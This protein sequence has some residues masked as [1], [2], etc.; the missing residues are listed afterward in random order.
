[1]TWFQAAAG[2]IVSALLTMTTVTLLA[3]QPMRA[4]IG[5]CFT[6]IAPAGQISKAA[7]VAA[8]AGGCVSAA[9][10]DPLMAMTIAALTAAAVGGEFSTIDQCHNMID[11]SV[12][13][14]IAE[15]LLKLPW[16]SDIKGLLQ[17]F[18][19]GKLPVKFSEL[20]FSIPALQTLPVYIE[21]GCS[22]AGA[23]GEYEKLAKEYAEA[24]K[25]CANFASDAAKAALDTVG[26][27]GESI[28][29]ALHGPS[30]HPGTQEE[31]T[32]Y[33]PTTLPDGIWTEKP[34]LGAPIYPGSGLPYGCGALICA[35][36]HVVM[37][38]E[39]GG[40]TLNKCSASCPE[41]TP[42]GFTPGDQCYSEAIW[43]PVQG[44]C[45]KAGKGYCCGDGKAAFEWGKCEPVCGRG[46]GLQDGECAT[47]KRWQT[48][49]LNRCNDICPN[50][51][52]YDPNAPTTPT[53]SFKPS[54]APQA[55]TAV[56]LPGQGPPGRADRGNVTAIPGGASVPSRG[57]AGGAILAPG[58]GRG[59]PGG[60]GPPG[61]KLVLHP[62]CIPCGQ[63]EYIKNNQCHGCGPKAVVNVAAH[64]C[65]PCARGQ[66][67]KLMAGVLTCAADCSKVAVAGR[68]SDAVS[69]NYITD[70]NDKNRCMVCKQGSKPN[71][72]HTACIV[73][74]RSTPE[75]KSFTAREAPVLSPDP[76]ER[77]PRPTRKD[78][79][80][81]SVAK[82]LTANEPRGT[83]VRVQC[84]PRMH[85][86]P[87]GAGC[88]PDL[89]GPRFGG[90]PSGPRPGGIL[91]RTPGGF[92]G[93]M[94]P[95]RT[96]R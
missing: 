83:A 87:R 28:H 56:G 79:P 26:G 15:A 14:L 66:V 1:M 31:Q 88:V 11:G 47:C 67:A 96:G 2:R 29:E 3:L 21:C 93:T 37:K 25:A 36:G 91:S 9:S 30:L 34:I 59:V 65:T 72:T 35:P 19:D 52:Y 84:P 41:A 73:V 55:A 20:I 18:V 6:A 80:R 82:P 22:V 85:P 17:D 89:G 86:N 16:P 39:V 10:G 13:K 38:T 54:G 46:K 23:P 24:A 53:V 71:A 90:V 51:V 63:N 60:G 44:V 49:T 77:R 75:K 48:S 61:E 94:V 7:E 70:P 12:G 64:T 42:I 57:G 76:I 78:N 32:C 95:G 62:M 8:K 5:D 69:T 68:R 50:G 58:V 81:G 27:W 4:D 45:K 33:G 43:T 74:A 92:R 40:K